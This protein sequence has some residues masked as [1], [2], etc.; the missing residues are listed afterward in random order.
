MLLTVGDLVQVRDPDDEVVGL[1]L[2]MRD[3]IHRSPEARVMWPDMPE[4][5]WIP[6]DV[7]WKVEEKAK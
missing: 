3:M 4:S 6:I 5:R 7:L 1:V 2:E